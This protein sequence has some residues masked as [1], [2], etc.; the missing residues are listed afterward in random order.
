M[1]AKRIIT[2]LGLLM[3]GMTACE[4]KTEEMSMKTSSSEMNLIESDERISSNSLP[5]ITPVE[6]Q[7]SEDPENPAGAM[8]ESYASAMVQI[9]AGNLKG[10][11]V[12]VYSTE[13]EVWIATAAH[14][15][16]NIK[17]S[18]KITF[19]DGFVAEA[20]TIEYL[21]PQDIAVIRLP[22]EALVYKSADEIMD[23][24]SIY[25]TAILERDAF[26]GAGVGDLA[27]AIGSKTGVAQESYAGVILEDYVYLED[28]G[29]YMILADVYVTPGMSGGGLFDAEGRLL[30]II[31]G[32]AEDGEVAVAPVTTILAMT[33]L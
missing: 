30:G 10:S 28:F 7:P 27:I 24:G 32:V 18:A 6:I 8:Q 29:T 20:K 25:H 14:V 23:H 33:D 4:K 22:R 17:E 3:L 15:L 5:T 26:D 31:C 11:G 13:E 1:K 12:I 2:I 9:V 19:F 16:A 21:E